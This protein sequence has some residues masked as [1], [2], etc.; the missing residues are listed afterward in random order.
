MNSRS[1][2]SNVSTLTGQL[3]T[4]KEFVREN[5]VAMCKEILAQEDGT[6]PDVPLL[7]QATKI[8]HFP[9]GYVTRLNIVMGEVKRQAMEYL[10]QTHED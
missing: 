1:V 9:E 6:Y 5:L 2:E 4:L 10:V 8:L 3:E 7:R